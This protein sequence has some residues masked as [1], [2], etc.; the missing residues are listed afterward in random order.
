MYS[1]ERRLYMNE[2]IMLSVQNALIFQKPLLNTNFFC[3]F[4]LENTHIWCHR[5]TCDTG[6]K[7][8]LAYRL[9]LL[10][11]DH[12]CYAHYNVLGGGNS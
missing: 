4:A 5:A 11:E 1:S 9:H 8:I 10:R 12:L 2:L 7:E 6:I 3:I